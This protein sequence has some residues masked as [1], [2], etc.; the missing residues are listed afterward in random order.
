MESNK[1][2]FNVELLKSYLDLLTEKYESPSSD[3]FGGKA[4]L[5]L[6]REIENIKALFEERQMDTT[7]K[8]LSA[9]FGMEDSERPF[10][11]SQII[12]QEEEDLNFKH[13]AKM[14]AILD[15][16]F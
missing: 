1:P 8:Q 5:T 4:R 7:W 2:E 6:R 3:P 14:N 10:A 11:S 9:V 15:S 16:D 13:K 12:D